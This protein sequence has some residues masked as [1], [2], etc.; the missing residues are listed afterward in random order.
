MLCSLPA[1]QKYYFHSMNMLLSFIP[2]IGH[3][4]TGNEKGLAF[5]ASLSI[6]CER[7]ENSCMQPA[8]GIIQVINWAIWQKR[9]V[10]VWNSLIRNSLDVL[11]LGG[12]TA[13]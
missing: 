12:Y 2:V 7:N 9:L 5:S 8:V 4:G 1:V 3:R 6:L 13:I 11:L 10:L